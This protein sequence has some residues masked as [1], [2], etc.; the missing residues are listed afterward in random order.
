MKRRIRHIDGWPD[1][2]VRV[3]NMVRVARQT[4]N[5]TQEDLAARLDVT[6]VTVNQIERGRRRTIDPDLLQAIARATGQEE[7]YFYGMHPP[8]AAL[9]RLADEAHLSP[10]MREIMPTIASLPAT[11]QDK[12]GSVLEQLLS[13]FQ[14]EAHAAS[15]R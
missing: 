3:G 15:N 9:A 7:A 2:A 13:F 5:L 6:R 8:S 11:Q 1:V 14:S 12:L 4:A 10:R